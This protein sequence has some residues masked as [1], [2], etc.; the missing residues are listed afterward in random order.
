MV[1][2]D[3]AHEGLSVSWISRSGLELNLKM[4]TY[5]NNPPSDHNRRQ[6][7]RRPE[8]LQQEVRRDLK[9]GIREEEDGHF[10]R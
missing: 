6:P 10:Q 7:D 8:S 9:H 1:I 4:L 3:D 2:G 5:H